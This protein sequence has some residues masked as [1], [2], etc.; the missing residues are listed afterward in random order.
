MTDPNLAIAS[1]D[2]TID[3]V[4]K[5]PRLEK[6]AGSSTAAQRF[7]STPELVHLVLGYLNRDR[8][9]LLVLGLVSKTL[10]AQALKI[11]VR[12]LDIDV[13]DAHKRLNFFKA[14]PTL[15]EHVRY[16]RLR[17]FH[18]SWDSFTPS[19]NAE[20][21]HCDWHAVNELLEMVASKSVSSRSPPLVDLSIFDSD[22]LCL[23]T[24]LKQQAVALDIQHVQDRIYL[25]ERSSLRS[26]SN[27]DEGTSVK[28]PLARLTLERLAD[29]IHD[30]RQGPGLRSFRFKHNPDT[31][32]PQSK[33]QQIWEHV[34]QHAPTLRHLSM[35]LGRLNFPSVAP[36]TAFPQLK[37]FEL[38]S[39][40]EESVTR[41]KDFLDG[42]ENLQ[43]LL[44]STDMAEPFSSRHTFPHLRH[45]GLNRLELDTD[46]AR[47]FAAR[48]R[49]VVVLSKTWPMPSV[50][51]A[52]LPALPALPPATPSPELYPNLARLSVYEP[53]E[54]QEHLDAGRSFTQIAIHRTA[55]HVQ[56]FL[57]PL[58]SN[59]AA[60]QRLTSLELSL[61][62]HDTPVFLSQLP[63][64]LGSQRLPNLAE[65]YFSPSLSWLQL[66][67][68][69]RDPV[70][71]IGRLMAALTSARSL[72]VFRLDVSERFTLP[73]D[74]L[75]DND[76]PPALEY[77]YL[78]SHCAG[79]IRRQYFRFVSSHPAA[80]I[81]TTES[82]GKR[83]RLQRVPQVFRQRITKE[84]VWCR[85]LNTLMTDTVLDHFS[86]PPSLSLD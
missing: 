62:W 61:G 53:D 15:L 12:Q 32:P 70:T 31:N 51:E 16:L 65:L 35:K 60:A 21:C 28:A 22:L 14:N 7:F 86:N 49:N 2:D 23:P 52:M 20:E 24:I 34:V 46:A 74:I 13:M 59:S 56:Q 77:F 64:M 38:Y 45:I 25:A 48:H 9:D 57:A 79:G 84:G 3:R 47:S 39:K 1:D 5:R 19:D 63:E 83:G 82:G 54:L 42:A 78:S 43:A 37:L 11:W 30:A 66:L 17:H 8:I 68:M 76:F 58:H 85:P 36:K 50:T 55:S 72:K 71:G 73:E 44:V 26:D 4:Q 41:M 6:E 27:G 75:R 80:H 18:S 81:V 40:G 29:I 10:R 33:L 67:S 69:N